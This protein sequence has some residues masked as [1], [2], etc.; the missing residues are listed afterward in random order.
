NMNYHPKIDEVTGLIN[1]NLRLP[2]LN[3]D[4][5]L[6]RVRHPAAQGFDINDHLVYINSEKIAQYR[7]VGGA[8]RFI[9]QVTGYKVSKEVTPD[10][11]SSA[12]INKVTGS[13]S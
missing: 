5:K 11:N 12:W 8:A 10:K 9:E 13:I 3:F 2:Y 6:L 1:Q 7:T 4:G